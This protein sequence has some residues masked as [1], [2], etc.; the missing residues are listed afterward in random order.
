MDL[1][2]LPKARGLVPPVAMLGN[3]VCVGLNYADHAV[4]TG[5][6]RLRDSLIFFKPPT[7]LSG[8]R[9]AASSRHGALLSFP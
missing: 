1:A 2:G 8:P 6:D 7:A 9:P 3:I 4:E 5:F